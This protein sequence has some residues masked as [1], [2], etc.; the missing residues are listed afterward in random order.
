MSEYWVALVYISGMGEY[1]GATR[2]AVGHRDN[3]WSSEEPHYK[4]CLVINGD[5]K[6]TLDLNC[7]SL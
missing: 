2:G 5:I 3:F 1:G 4:F 7:L 6:T